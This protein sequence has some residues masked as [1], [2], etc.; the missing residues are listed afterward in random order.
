MRKPQTCVVTGGSKGITITGTT[1]DSHTLLTNAGNT[2]LHPTHPGPPPK[3][4]LAE[5]NIIYSS[6][7][8]KGSHF[9][10]SFKY[11]WTFTGKPIP[12]KDL[13][14]DSIQLQVTWN[15]SNPHTCQTWYF[16]PTFINKNNNKVT[17]NNR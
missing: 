3:Q 1:T 5:K 7:K 12:P 17:Q 14:N 9:C 8:K 4:P 11:Y 13:E 16:Y 6:L 10:F 15:H 2:H